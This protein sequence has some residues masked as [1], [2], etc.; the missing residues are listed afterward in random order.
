[1]YTVIGLKPWPQKSDI[2]DFRSRKAAMEHAKALFGAGIYEQVT[3]L[4]SARGKGVT[5]A[6]KLTTNHRCTI[7]GARVASGTLCPECALEEEEIAGYRAGTPVHGG[8]G[9]ASCS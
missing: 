3:V 7:C 5:V 4:H 2:A 9:D 1:V 8:S 6:A